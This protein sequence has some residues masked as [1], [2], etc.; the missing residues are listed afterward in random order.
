MFRFANPD[1]LYLLF[2]LPVLIGFYFYTII[3]KKKAIKKYG[4]PELLAA[5]MPE[6]S[7]K[8]QHLKFWLLFGAITLIIFVIA[9]PQ[10]GSKLETVKRQGIE[11]MVCL[12]V[13]NS[14]MSEDV[15]PNRLEKAKQMLSRLT[16]GL[17]NDKVGL[18][19]FAGD[20]F[21]QLPIT[22][23][24]ISAKMFLSSINPSMVSSQGTSIGAAI[25]LAAR[26]FTP[27]ETSDKAI[28]L[29]TDGENHEDDAVGAAQKASEKG[30]YVNIVGIG[31]PQGAPIP[32]GG[33]NNYMK[34]RDGNVVITKL[35]EQM[36]QE[37]AAAGN[38]MYVR[39]DNTNTALKAL[40][41]ELDKMTKAELDSKIYSEYDEQ[42][43]L[44]AWIV[45]VLL[46][47]EFLTLDRKN[48]I[49][50]KVKLFS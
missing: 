9:G 30:I 13:S 10:F 48:R 37:I 45:L 17:S 19:V 47:A 44:L 43:Q 2:I 41:T 42:F 12:D 16:D 34:D 18:I 14:M 21:T 25:N 22:S 27:N 8:R 31:S 7:S 38:G 40:Q 35:N 33:N 15:A 11:I 39:A 49:F 24:Y 3:R 36:C 32:A 29:I 23:D 1:F 20:A 50:R 6:V 26:S 28:I 5:L 4:N 46:I